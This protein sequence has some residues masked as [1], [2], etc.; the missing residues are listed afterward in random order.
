M[1]IKGATKMALFKKKGKALTMREKKTTRPSATSL[2]Q[3][4][5][6]SLRGSKE[7]IS[8]EVDEGGGSRSDD[9]LD[10]TSSRKLD[11]PQSSVAKVEKDSLKL[12][13]HD[14]VGDY[15]STTFP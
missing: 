8:R 12:E 15:V 7:K 2:S 11:A 13:D 5:T 3:E 4:K 6:N 10:G 1:S 9:H 14:T